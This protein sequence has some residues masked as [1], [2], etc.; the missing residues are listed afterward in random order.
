[1]FLHR[2]NC[3]LDGPIRGQHDDRCVRSHSS[4]D[5]EKVEPASSRHPEIAHDEIDLSF[6][7]DAL[8]GCDVRCSDA[9]MSEA[10]HDD[11]EG[12][13]QALVVVH[14]QNRRWC[15]VLDFLAGK[16]PRRRAPPLAAFSA[17]MLPPCSSTIRLAIASPRPVPSALVV[18]NGKK[19][20]GRISAEK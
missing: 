7:Q 20:F 6:C 12:L 18:K 9:V 13:P 16:R 17:V 2:L 14:Y 3:R 4:N 11:A 15:H 1:A 8:S 10:P 5:I 19:T